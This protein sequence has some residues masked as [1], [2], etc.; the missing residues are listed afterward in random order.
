VLTSVSQ[1]DPIKV[2]FS[3]SDAEYLALVEATKPGSEDLL[4]NAARIPLTL[5]LVDGSVY[6]YKGRI[7]FIDRQ[8][9]QQTGAIRIAAIFPNP[10]NVLRPGQFGRVSAD[11]EVKHG[12]IVVPQDAVTDLQGQK[13]VCVAGPD[14]KVHVVNVTLGQQVGQDWIVTSGLTPGMRVITDNLQ[15][16][17]EGAPVTPQPAAFAPSATDGSQPA[18]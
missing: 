1:L 18:R 8:M 14:N 7:V 10:G 5:T 13:Q 2:Y 3:M 12:V 17:H 11:T 4:H 16:L 9:N 15:K 6:P